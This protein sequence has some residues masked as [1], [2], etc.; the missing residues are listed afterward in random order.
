[1]VMRVVSRAELEL[2]AVTAEARQSLRQY[3]GRASR[4]KNS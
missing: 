3:L 1:M 4:L 2:E